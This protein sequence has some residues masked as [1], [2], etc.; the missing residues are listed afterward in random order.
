MNWVELRNA[1]R[2]VV[3]NTFR[4][5]AHYYPTADVSGAG[6]AVSIR[7]HSLIVR[8]GDLDREGYSQVMEDVE[9]MVFVTTEVMTNSI[10]RGGYI[11]ID[12]NMVVYRLE[13]REPSRDNYSATFQVRR[14]D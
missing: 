14:V 10:Q 11:R 9:R 12:D 3:H 4:R 6:V 7:L 13:L 5:A 1:A 2:A 8:E